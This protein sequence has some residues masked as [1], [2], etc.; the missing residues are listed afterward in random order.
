MEYCVVKNLDVGAVTWAKLFCE[1]AERYGWGV[2]DTP[3]SGNTYRLFLGDTISK[4]VLCMDGLNIYLLAAFEGSSSEISNIESTDVT[5]LPSR[6]ELR[7]VRQVI[8]GLEIR[9]LLVNGFP[10]NTQELLRLRLPFGE[11]GEKSVCF[12]GETR[13]EKN[14]ELEIAVARRLVK[15]GF[16]CIHMSP[17][18][19]S[20]KEELANAGV[21]VMEYV[22]H[23]LYINMLTNY[24]FIVNTSLRES[25]WI[26]GIEGAIL[27]GIPIAPNHESSGLTEWCP[28]HL[29][30]NYSS[31]IEDI[32][33]KV[34]RIREAD[35]IPLSIF[36]W[37]D[38]SQYFKRLCEH[39]V[40]I[41]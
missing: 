23:S 15:E 19:V 29:L 21:S 16:S 4:E 39:L 11:K 32:L 33:K 10:V 18:A 12:A 3:C 38:S 40:T 41:K 24:R 13:P 14:P 25:L 20:Y 37:Y 26:S 9:K 28:N 30:Y 5:L 34:T 2:V 36:S 7:K 8:P 1:Q 22:Q 6:S 27:G 17:F 31:P 35:A